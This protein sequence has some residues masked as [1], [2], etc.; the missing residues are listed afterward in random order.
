MA[1]EIIPGGLQAYNQLKRGTLQHADHLTEDRWAKPNLYELLYPMI[2]TA[3][4]QGFFPRGDGGIDWVITRGDHN[5]VLSHLYDK[6]N[7]SYEQLVKE[8]YF[9]PD[10]AEAQAARE[11]ESTVVVDMNQLRLSREGHLEKK[12]CSLIIRTESG[13]IETKG[14]W[15]VPRQ[16]PNREEQ[17]GMERLGFVAKHLRKMY[18]AE[19]VE[20][21]IRVPSPA[22]IRELFKKHPESISFWWASSLGGTNLK[23]DFFPL[24]RGMSQ[25]YFLRGER[26][27]VTAGGALERGAVSG[28]QPKVIELTAE[29][30]LAW[31]RRYIPDAAWDSWRDHVREL[32]ETQ[33]KKT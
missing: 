9:H 7:N 15:Q 6:G 27:V 18:D 4:G 22:Y 14:E 8:G 28:A 16:V 30:L 33:A 13:L 24:G 1:L 29:Q 2:C 23:Y 25:R 12:M 19:T 5:L 21:K 10:N 20:T 26:E 3:D 11:A 17:K 32:I 31:S